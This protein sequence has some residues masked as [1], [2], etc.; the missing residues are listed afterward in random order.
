MKIVKIEADAFEFT[1]VLDFTFQKSIN[2][3]AVATLSGYIPN[4]KEAQ[5]VASALE[6]MKV[7]IAGFDQDGNEEIILC[8]ILE[9]LKIENQNGLKKLTITVASFTKLMDLKEKRHTFQNAQMTY[10]ELVSHIISQYQSA[11]FVMSIAN[12]PLSK[13]AVQYKETDW[14]FL[15]RLCS[16]HKQVIVP[17]TKKQDGPR[18]Y[19]GTPQKQSS[20]NLEPISYELR[21]RVGNFLYKGENKVDSLSENDEITYFVKER[22]FRDIGEPIW[23]HGKNLLV[24]DVSA[25]WEGS[26]LVC[27]TILKTAAGFQVPKRYN[28]KMIGASL[29]GKVINVENDMVKVHLASDE[30]QELTSAKWF[31]YSTVYSSPDG[32]GWYAMPEIGDEIRLYFP[33]E[34]E[35]H[36]YVVSAVHVDESQ[37]APSNYRT[38]PDDKSLRTKWGKEILLQPSAI[39]IRNAD[40]MEIVIDDESGISIT[41]GKKIEIQADESIGITSLSDTIDIIGSKKVTLKQSGAYV[42]LSDGQILTNAAQVRMEKK[43]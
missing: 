31:D 39:V 37:S 32:T 25:T 7:T 13:L 19:F 4:E 36:A 11:G 29:D 12:S 18:F 22:E 14:A 34:K 5:Y 20:Q 10:Q 27:S 23:F 24:Y 6:E 43:D 21:K 38:N 35:K 1:H 33:T 30:E 15:I 17:F 42:E 2:E 26:E 9:D 40:N 8:G 16:H 28:E 3:H 41:C